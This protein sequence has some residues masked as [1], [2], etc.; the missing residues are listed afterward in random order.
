MAKK[1]NGLN[2]NHRK[3]DPKLRMVANCT[4]KVNAVRAEFTAALT[5]TGAA[6]KQAI[7]RSDDALKIVPSKQQ[8]V[9]KLKSISRDVLVNVFIQMKT[10]GQSKED[11]LPKVRK[12]AT[13]VRLHRGD[14]A[15]ATVE[16]RDLA[17]LAEVPGVTSVEMGDTLAAP[18]PIRSDAAK[19][20]PVAR[21]PM[22]NSLEALHHNGEGV[23][24]GIIDV[25][26]F[27]F[28][29][30]DFLDK[31]GETRFER[32]WDQGG[33]TR[34]TPAE[35]KTGP[36]GYGAEIQRKEMN[37]AIKA[38][39][40]VGAPAT[41]LEPQ[42]QMVPGSHGTHVA[43]IAAGNL[44]V[45]P[46][47]K[48][49]GVLISLTEEDEDRRR[50][51]YDST[52]LVDAVEYLIALSKELAP[53][54]KPPLPLSINISLGTNGH[55]HD[56]SAACCR[57]IDAALS[58]QGRCVSVAAGNAG[59]E[60]AEFPGDLGYFLGRIH[61]KGS[62]PASDLTTDIEVEVIGNT[63][64]DVS[65]NELEIWYSPQDRFEVSL[66]PPGGEWLGPYKPREFLQNHRLQREGHFVSIYNELY[67][68][69]NGANYIA[70][71][72]TPFFDPK[73]VVG[74][75]AGTW[76]VRLHGVEIRSGAFHGWIE[77]DDPRPAG[78]VGN[79][80][81]WRFPSCFSQRSNVDNSSISTL[82]TAR[83]VV[84]VG[85][86]DSMRERI[87]ISSSQGPTRDDR[88]KPDVAA[89]GTD[90]VAAKGFTDGKEWIAMT[91]TSMASPYVTG[92]A[93]L[94]L[95]AQR[96]LTASQIV[97]IMQRTAKPLPGRGF[98][99]SNDGGFG[100][101]NATECVREAALVNKREER[102][103]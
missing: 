81:A 63:R 88:F 58:V 17:K 99:W 93:G 68:P 60:V 59:Q 90:V 103:S 30:A 95:A 71:Y 54:G 67:H 26:G 40:K 27:D 22:E 3:L 34:P 72:L 13:T 7:V 53:K 64:V 85:N 45:C 56:G 75:K 33:T 44:G 87:H 48:L 57:W 37:K 84:A 73:F 79:V 35:L 43:S 1:K 11:V 102:H 41:D 77:R 98:P 83:H 5:V 97:G 61:T 15:T 32:I 70:I 24:I 12:L 9:P 10:H 50:S 92:V 4:T 76:T 51:F 46:G 38:A 47:A 62:L 31:N 16:L 74:V 80:E 94:M 101:I 89:P 91:G 14:Q 66:R 29:H 25:Q 55:A 8:I 49:A 39:S 78:R 18:V 20:A 82:A 52:R 86:L 100:C 23:L 2:V 65:E 28:A 96:E 36:F 19:G 21:V 42:S 69:A 6:G